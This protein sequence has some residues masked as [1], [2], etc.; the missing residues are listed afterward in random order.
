MSPNNI[1]D[2]RRRRRVCCRT[3]TTTCGPQRDDI[4]YVRRRHKECLLETFGMFPGDIVWTR[5]RLRQ[6]IWT[7]H[8]LH[9]LVCILNQSLSLFP[10]TSKLNLGFSQIGF[11]RQTLILKN[12]TR[13]SSRPGEV[14]RVDLHFGSPL[15]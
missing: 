3:T 10:Y 8:C 11:D 6:T 12:L 4:G 7:H 13:G 15:P 5:L 2:V 14:K 9:R 1:P